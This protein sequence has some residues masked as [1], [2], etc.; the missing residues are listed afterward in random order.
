MAIDFK[1]FDEATDLKALKADIK[2]MQEN[3]S[4]QYKDVPLGE[5]EVKI[6]K[7]E[8][9]E[10]K[11]HN[12][13]LICWFKILEGEHKNSLIFMNQVITKAFQIHIACE[14]LRSIAPDTKVE[15]ESYEQFND[16]IL[17]IAEEIDGNFEYVLNYD[18]NN[19][20]YHTFEITDVFDVA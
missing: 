9:I 20:G 8:L 11:N 16:L 1:K 14:F 12:P 15:F 10:N 6:E 4:S 3:S 19:K 18:E 2:E 13:M 7:L 5:Y 17:D